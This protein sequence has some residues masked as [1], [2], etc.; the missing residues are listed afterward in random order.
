MVYPVDPNSSPIIAEP[1]LASTLRGINKCRERIEREDKALQEKIRET[2]RS[3]I[4]SSTTSESKKV[5]SSSG[6]ITD[7]TDDSQNE[8]KD[9]F[10]S[11]LKKPQK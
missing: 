3:S 11:Y 5:I 6:Q 9:L 10:L 7:S 1:Q 4:T 8:T 2:A